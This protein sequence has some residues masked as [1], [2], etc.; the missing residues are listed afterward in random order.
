MYY[1][2]F[3]RKYEND[4]DG[5]YIFLLKE[6]TYSYLSLHRLNNPNKEHIGDLMEAKT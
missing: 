2:A 1:N 4:Q 5:I 6:K 3:K